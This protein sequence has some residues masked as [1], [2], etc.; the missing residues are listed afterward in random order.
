MFTTR[1]GERQV[2]AAVVATVGRGEQS[3]AVYL[4]SPPRSLLE[5]SCCPA[6]HCTQAAT[7][8]LP[9]LTTRSDPSLYIGPLFGRLIAHG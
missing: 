8:A 2:A 9:P 4:P 7:P 5:S 1:A 3:G 6:P